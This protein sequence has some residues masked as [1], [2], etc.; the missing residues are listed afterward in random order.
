MIS[1]LDS[2]GFENYCFHDLVPSSD[3]HIVIQ[4]SQ[5][6]LWHAPPLS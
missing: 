1:A 2:M 6:L 5:A 4:S 3:A